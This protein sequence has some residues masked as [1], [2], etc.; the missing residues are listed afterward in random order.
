MRINYV[1]YFVLLI[2]ADK[3][4]RNYLSLIFQDK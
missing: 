3:K 4:F 1:N 2:D